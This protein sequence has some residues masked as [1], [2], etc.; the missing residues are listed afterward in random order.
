MILPLQKLLN[1]DPDTQFTYLLVGLMS[2]ALNSCCV[3][4]VG[5]APDLDKRQNII[6]F[7]FIG[8]LEKQIFC[9][10]TYAPFLFRYCKV[11]YP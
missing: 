11:L 2:D 4:S 7:C 8:F 1:G 5:S 9:S 3:N 6:F 10:L